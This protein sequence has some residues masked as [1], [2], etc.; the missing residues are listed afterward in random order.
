MR[1]LKDCKYTAFISYAHADDETWFRWVTQFRNELDRGLATVRRRMKLP[2][3]HLSGDNGPVAGMLAEQLK[4]RIEESFAMIIVV[5]DN[6]AQSDWCLKELE[7]FRTLFG[8]DGFRER[9]YVVA[10]SEPAMTSVAGGK[11]WRELMPGKD[12]LWMPFFNPMASD[13]PLDIY[14][15]PEV[16][17]P[18]FR[19]QFLRLREDFESKLLRAMTEPV[20]GG[21]GPFLPPGVNGTGTKPAV[22]VDIPT[23]V[24]PPGLPAQPRPA[25][26]TALGFVPAGATAQA[27]TA[28][29]DRLRT[30]GIEVRALAQDAVFDDFSAFVGAERLV[31]AFDDA[32]LMMAAMAPGGHLQLQRE[33]WVRKGGAPDRVHWLDLRAS[34]A[35]AAPD[36]GSAAAYVATQTTE[37]LDTSALLR[38]LAPPPPP[39][40]GAPAAAQAARGV[41]IYIESNTH[42]KEVNLWLPLGQQI[43]RKWNELT[44]R[45]DPARVPP[46]ALSTRG[47]PVD[48]LDRFPTLDDAD[49]IVLLWGHKDEEA[50]LAQIDKVERKTTP[51]SEMP[52]GIVAYLMPPQQSAEPVP[53]WGWQVL[54]FDAQDEAAIDVVADERDQLQGFLTQVLARWRQREQGG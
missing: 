32:P 53:A 19:D 28:V 36:A 37:T 46:L 7:Y 41:R 39:P 50:L 8:D 27:L 20:G 35:A 47:L 43:R 4:Q 23:G 11:A 40:P 45:V 30:A 52:P 49:G 44:R 26:V 54:R 34:P 2:P 24:A 33:A 38:L 15:A 16:L 22:Q 3:M 18:G 17:A 29:A 25:G 12:Q 51:G 42:S 9:L 48:R 14:M 6:Y 21:P 5:H 31:L 13:R 1:A 10:M